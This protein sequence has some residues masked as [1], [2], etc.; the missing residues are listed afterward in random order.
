LVTTSEVSEPK[1]LTPEIK[2]VYDYKVVLLPNGLRL[3][4]LH[5]KQKKS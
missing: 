1:W 5:T 2:K 4:K 3:T